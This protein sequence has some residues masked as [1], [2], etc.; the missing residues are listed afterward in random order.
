MIYLLL[1]IDG[2]GYHFAEGIWKQSKPLH[3]EWPTVTGPNW[4][5]ILTGKS[6]RQHGIYNN[7]T[8]SYHRGHFGLRNIVDRFDGRRV[9]ISNWRP[10]RKLFQRVEFVH[11]E[12]VWTVAETYLQREEHLFLVVNTDRLDH[13]GH[14]TSWGSP[15]FRRS[16]KYITRRTQRLLDLLRGPYLCV[17]VADHGGEGNEHD[18]NTPWVREVPLMWC[19]NQPLH[20]PRISRTREIYGILQDLMESSGI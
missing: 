19:T 18:A 11:T 6:I 12:S 8:I 10:F 7:E 20:V 16:V 17:G 15:A 3:N 1:L 4:V 5:S 14:R 9:V 13:V 2:L